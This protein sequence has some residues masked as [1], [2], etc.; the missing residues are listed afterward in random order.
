MGAAAGAGAGRK[1]GGGTGLAAALEASCRAIT[2]GIYFEFGSADLKPASEPTL[3]QIAAILQRHPD[4]VLSIEGHTDSIGGAASNLALSKRRAEAVR[5]ALVARYG[6]AP[7]RLEPRGFG[8]TR[9]IAPN[10]AIEGRARNRRVELA[11]KC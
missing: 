4:W 9:P 8:L 1:G 2:Y 10:A 11:R 5:R 3:R 6:I 7:A